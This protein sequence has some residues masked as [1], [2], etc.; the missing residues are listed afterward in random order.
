MIYVINSEILFLKF[1]YANVYFLIE[2]MFQNLLQCSE[3][4]Q[5]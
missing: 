1:L 5:Q 2:S 4:S 3:C